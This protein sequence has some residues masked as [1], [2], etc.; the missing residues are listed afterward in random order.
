MDMP[1]A[2][3]LAEAARARP[4]ADFHA[5]AARIEG[6]ALR[7]PFIELLGS[8]D[9][10]LRLKA[11]NLQPYGSFK[12]RCGMNALAA[13]DNA[14]L[15]RG[16]ATVSAG[17]FAQGLAYAARRRGA[18]LTAHVPTAANPVKLRAL[19]ELGVTIVPQSPDDWM[20]IAFTCHTGADDGHFVHPVCDLAVILANGTIGLEMAADWPEMDTVVVPVGGGGLI[21]GIALAMRALGRNVRVVGCEVEGAAPLAAAKGAGRPIAVGREASFVDAIGSTMILEAMWPL[22]DDLVDDVVVVPVENAKR[23]LRRL[24][25]RHHM[26]VE[27]A[28]A[29]ALA[30][31]L[32]PSLQGARAG[33]VLSGGNID[34]ATFAQILTE[35]A[36]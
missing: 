25:E 23:A 22:L 16:V 34:T 35:G 17:N 9:R 11:E 30:A 26:V 12:I 7:T 5:A 21:S 29:V 10:Q 24:A 3:G 2:A 15:A 6:I 18:N 14:L 28:A 13:F 36:A 8:A 33:V 19:E 32:S 27:G 31:A 20:R 1:W 4:L